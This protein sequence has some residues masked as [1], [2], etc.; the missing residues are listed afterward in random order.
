MKLN[1]ISIDVIDNGYS[2]SGSQYSNL[3][4][5]NECRM[6]FETLD[7]SL[8]FIKTQLITPKEKLDIREQERSDFQAR[9]KEEEQRFAQAAT[10][11]PVSN[12]FTD[13]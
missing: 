10:R 4:G 12:A 8:E 2:V 6:C 11:F 5:S 7:A 13:R 9:R 1:N 3:L